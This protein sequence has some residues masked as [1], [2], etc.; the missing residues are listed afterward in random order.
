VLAFSGDRDVRSGVSGQVQA[1]LAEDCAVFRAIVLPVSGAIFV[2][3]YLR[4][5]VEAAFDHPRP[6]GT[7]GPAWLESARAIA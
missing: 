3:I 7:S 5:P 2:E 4:H 1:E 6:A